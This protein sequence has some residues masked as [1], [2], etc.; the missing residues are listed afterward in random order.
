MTNPKNDTLDNL[1]AYIQ[2]KAGDWFDRIGANKG[3][4]LDFVLPEEVPALAL[5]GTVRRNLYLSV[6][7]ALN[8]ALKHSEASRIEISLTML[9]ENGFAWRVS[10]NGR[11]FETADVSRFS[12]GLANMRSRLEEIGGECLITS[13]VGQGTTITFRV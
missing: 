8:N 7:E 6:K 10:D 9:G 12:N 2:E 3:M 13:H 11:G 5:E 1:A 4:V